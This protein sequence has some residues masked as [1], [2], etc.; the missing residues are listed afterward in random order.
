MSL[1][2]GSLAEYAGTVEPW[3]PQAKFGMFIHWGPYSV[4]GV[5]ASWPIMTPEPQES[6]GRASITQAEYEKLPERFNPTEFDAT[7][8]V[9]LARTSG[10]RYMVFTAK[11]HDGFCMFDSAFT[12]YSIM[13]TPYGKDI[14]AQLASA[15]AT[16]DMPFGFY[17][18]QP[19]LH[20]PYYRDTSKL[21][22]ENWAGEADR[23]EWFGY[24]AYL[25]A[26]LTEL[27]TRYGK[28]SEIWFD[29][30]R[31]QERFDPFIINPWLKS[32]WPG[33]MI[34][35]RNGGN[36]SMSA[37][38]R[39]DQRLL[40]R[41]AWGDFSTPEQEIPAERIPDRPWETCMT[42]NDTW[43]Y[44]PSDTNYKSAD[45]LIRVLV[46]VVDKGGNL[47]LN[48]GPRP[49]GTIQ[50]EFVERLGEIGAWLRR[51][52][53]GIYATRPS[54]LPRQD[55]GYTTAKATGKTLYLHVTDWDEDDGDTVTV[56]GLPGAMHEVTV[57]G[58]PGL[59]VPVNAADGRATFT[60]PRAAHDPYITVLRI[61]HG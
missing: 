36:G 30:L 53:E 20:H 19:D 51:N 40:P 55:W 5:E 29:G 33:L 22:K 18:S 7:A 24:L 2:P 4:A 14:A 60:V 27:L 47:L 23:P 38:P 32:T 45:T 41:A 43:A 42:I 61:K 28:V 9:E 39:E 54:G 52:G 11:H 34:N 31:S 26:Q 16:A 57:L 59:A 49:D 17:Y 37:I 48:V 1:D 10:Q 3:W 12:R 35:D 46:E 8:L 25:R 13:N 15:A 6:Q 21:A 56:A 50:P 44:N 58:A